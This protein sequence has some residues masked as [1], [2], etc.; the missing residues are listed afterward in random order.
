[1]AA[2]ALNPEPGLRVGILCGPCAGL[3]SVDAHEDADIPFQPGEELP[4]EDRAVQLLVVG[5]RAWK[6]SRPSALQ[7]LLECRRVL[8]PGGHLLLAQDP[9][10]EQPERGPAETGF[11]GDLRA[12]VAL[13]GLPRVPAAAVREIGDA[14]LGL[15]GPVDVAWATAFVKPNRRVS[16]NPLVSILIPA[17]NE[18]FFAACLDSALAQTYVN[19]E[20]VVCDDSEGDGIRKIVANRS[21]LRP[22]RYERN[23]PRLFPRGNFTRCFERARGEFIKFLCDDDLLERGCVANLLD[24]FRLAD[25]ITLATSRRRRIDGAGRPMDDMPATLGIVESS[26]MIAGHTLANAVIMMGL[27]TIGEPSTA[28]FRKADFVDNAPGY[29]RFAGADGH[30]IIDLIMWSALLLKGNA[31][32]LTERQSSFRFHPGQRQHDPAKLDRN[33]ASIRDLQATWLALGLHE[34]QRPDLILAKA[35]PPVV[36]EEWRQ[37]RINGYSARRVG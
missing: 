5:A 6:L 26:A 15:V 30:G 28:L 31:V 19:V 13:V 22:I 24:A 27:N 33:V 1:V 14:M 25:D 3:L 36:D 8:A 35:F 10:G 2:S 21:K 9:S 23:E 20:I 11:G 7:F 17:Y 4:F 16:G 18:A 37:R 29:F 34:W 12:V 32:Y